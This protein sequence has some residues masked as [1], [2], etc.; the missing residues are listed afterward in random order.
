VAIIK[1]DNFGGELP[2]VQPRSL[3][4]GAAQV[5][6]NLLATSMD[7][8]PLQDDSAVATGVSGAKTLYR[9][10]RDPGCDTDG[11]AHH[12]LTRQC[13]GI[14]PGLPRLAGSNPR[15]HFDAVWDCH[16]GV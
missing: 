8:R 3:P 5:N 6:S 2:R 12:I 16:A 14:H 4:P 10:A 1:I 15:S 13:S 9:L 7:F 11:P